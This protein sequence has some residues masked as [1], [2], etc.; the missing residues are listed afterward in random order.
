[1]TRVRSPRQDFN[2]VVLAEHKPSGNVW[3]RHYVT[4][5]V[6][7]RDTKNMYGYY[8]VAIF[9]ASYPRLSLRAKTDWERVI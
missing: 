1:M 8:E 9:P 4:R 7:E 5:T 3:L 2:W 6:A